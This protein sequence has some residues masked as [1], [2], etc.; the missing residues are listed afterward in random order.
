M[1]SNTLKSL[2][3]VRPRTVLRRAIALCFL[4]PMGLALSAT[5]HAQTANVDTVEIS[6]V[7]PTY[8]DAITASVYVYNDTGDGLTGTVNFSV[9]GGQAIP[10]TLSDGVGYADLG[11]L[12]IGSHTLSA[13]YVANAQYGSSSKSI[14]FQV[15]DAQ[16]AYVGTQGTTLFGAGSVS[17]VEGVAVD[18]QDNLYISD[19]A[20]SVVK[21]EDTLGNVTTIPLTGLKNPVGL[22]LDSAGNLYVADTGNNRI[23]K[24]DTSGTQTVVPVTGLSG[25]TYLAYDLYNDILYIV[26]PGNSQIVSFTPSSGAVAAIVTGMT[27]L[28]SVSVDDYGDVY[29]SDRV[30]GFMEYD[31]PG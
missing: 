7:S 21:K 24:Y 3:P 8:I 15:T 25:P 27:A 22:A 6:P 12:S 23:L 5:V 30:A 28:G 16:L 4:V 14:N 31:G 11:R 19:K 2:A 26:D 9:D 29:F 20:A 17:D 10:S 13:T 1:Q 18:V